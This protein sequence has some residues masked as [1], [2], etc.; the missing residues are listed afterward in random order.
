MSKELM[1]RAAEAASALLKHK[2]YEI[3]ENCYQLDE[4]DSIYIIARDNE[5]EA[6]VFCELLVRSSAEERLPEGRSADA[7]RARG[8]RAATQYLM[9]HSD[10]IDPTSLRFD[11]IAMCCISDDRAFLRHQINHLG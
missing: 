1:T 4:N 7:A 10:F 5:D 8:E 6:L 11:E 9:T 3:I 2:G